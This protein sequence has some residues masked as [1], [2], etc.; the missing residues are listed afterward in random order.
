MYQIRPEVQERLHVHEDIAP[1]FYECWQGYLDRLCHWPGFRM[2]FGDTH[3]INASYALAQIQTLR[4]YEGP[5]FEDEDNLDMARPEMPLRLITDDQGE[6]MA[7]F[8]E[9]VKGSGG[10]IT[11]SI[12]YA[13]EMLV[14]SL[15]AQTGAYPMDDE[16]V[17][18]AAHNIGVGLVWAG[19]SIDRKKNV[20]ETSDLASRNIDRRQRFLYCKK[21]W[22]KM[23]ALATPEYRKYLSATAFKERW[24]EDFEESA[25]HMDIEAM[26]FK[27]A[28]H[29]VMKIAD[30]DVLGKY[31]NNYVKPK[32]VLMNSHRWMLKV[33]NFIERHGYD[34][35]GDYLKARKQLSG[36]FGPPD[37]DEEE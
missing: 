17:A 20:L 19:I 11:A 36:H 6:L 21:A 35:H 31:G 5:L 18:W 34:A 30:M 16:E 32:Q 33:P 27:W 28:Q 22:Q 4:Y 7:A 24:C 3:T 23:L 37:I 12:Q 29:E 8:K 10:F 14:K 1:A 9:Y 15:G 13:T 25:Q 26:Y 2:T